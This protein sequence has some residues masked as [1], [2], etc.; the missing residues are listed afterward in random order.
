[1]RDIKYIRRVGA[2]VY[3]YI[4]TVTVKS[5]PKARVTLVCKYNALENIV[6]NKGENVLMRDFSSYVVDARTSESA[7]FFGKFLPAHNV[8]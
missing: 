5:R 8:H 3:F 7:S 1:M 6:P 4:A 2:G